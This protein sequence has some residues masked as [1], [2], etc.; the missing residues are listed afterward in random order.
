[1]TRTNCRHLFKNKGNFIFNCKLKKYEHFS[2]TPMRYDY[3]RLQEVKKGLFKYGL[4]SE[5]FYLLLL[6]KC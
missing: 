1:M 3:Y 6:Y 5:I 4:K 2:E